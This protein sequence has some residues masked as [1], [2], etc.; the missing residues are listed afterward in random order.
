ME[1]IT[2][3]R[4]KKILEERDARETEKKVISII[5]EVKR[6]GDTA[7]RKFTEKFDGA[8]IKSIRVPAREIAS[9][10]RN[11]DTKVMSAVARTAERLRKYHAAQLP[12]KFAVKERGI[13]CECMF[14]PVRRAG[15]YVPAGQ[16]QLVSTVLMTVLPAQIAGV[17]EIYAASPASCNGKVN[18]LILGILGYLGIKDVFAVGGAQAV[19]AFACGTETVPAVD[20]IAGPGNKYV[21]TAKRLVYG[22][23]GIDLPAGPSELA[24]FTD[25]SADVD[26]IEADLKAQIEHTGGLG[27]LITTGEKT[28]RELSARIRGG[29]WLKVRDK[30]EAVKVINLIAPEHLQIMCKY[31]RSIVKDVVAGAIFAG[32]WSSA[33]LGDYFAGPSHVLPTGRTARFASGLSVYTFLRNCAVVEASSGFYRRYGELMETLPQTEGLP[34]HR[35][36]ISVRRRKARQCTLN[37]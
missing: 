25:G 23:V 7:L 35:E 13:S 10:E 16:A 33:V 15:L 28:G 5:E 4:L 9:A 31:P 34:M 24:V 26:F 6:N 18:P 30:Q 14:F 27:I 19:A 3:E 11:I 8:K 37:G 21:D 32:D 2:V 12:E 29:Y 1:K 17:K 20:V 22:K 36:S